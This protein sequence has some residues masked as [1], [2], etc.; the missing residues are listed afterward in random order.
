MEY[1]EGKE[2]KGPLP[3][4]RAIEL[5]CQILDA[6]DAAHRK[7]ITHRDLKPA[8]I[9]VTK[10]GVKVLDFGLAKIESPGTV[11]REDGRNSKYPRYQQH[12]QRYG[13]IPKGLRGA[14]QNRVL[15]R[16]SPPD[17]HTGYPTP[18][19]C[20]IVLLIPGAVK[21][22]HQPGGFRADRTSTH[23]YRISGRVVA[24]LP[25]M[26]VDSPPKLGDV[27]G[28]SNDGMRR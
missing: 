22:N 11:G 8:N 9:M 28:D 25:G 10:S 23:S 24:E 26:Q 14:S 6:L 17:S 3:L 27:H 18:P 16:R 4:A 20:E 1:V 19:S 13:R 7:G 2:L 21:T 5:A 15:D 12:M